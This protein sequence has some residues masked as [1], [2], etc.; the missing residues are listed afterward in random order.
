M[1]SRFRRNLCG[2]SSSHTVSRDSEPQAHSRLPDIKLPKFN[3]DYANWPS[4]REL[5]SAVI[6]QHAKLNDVEK[7]HYLRSC[8]QS[9]A[10]QL[11][12]GL[13][14]TRDSL[15]SSWDLLTSR[16]ENKRLIMQSHLDNLF[17]LAHAS[18]KSAA[19]LTKLIST[20][21]EANKALHSLG[22][23]EYMWDCFLVHHVSRF[24]DRDTREAWETS[25][26]SSQEY[27]LLNLRPS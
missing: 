12:R 23:T 8:V 24:L 5:F 2:A 6:L 15:Q 7:L 10:E 20:V 3:G 17:S 19:S 26:G 16:Y 13:P 18:S 21:S 4:F 1:L 9:P 14:L 27:P 25:L 11:I 22:M